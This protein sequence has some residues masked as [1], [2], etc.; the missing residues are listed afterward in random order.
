MKVLVP[1]AYKGSLPKI[2]DAEIVII[3]GSQPVAD[4]HLDAEVLVAWGQP[5]E[6][7]KDSAQRLTRLRLVQAFLAGPDPVVA[8][9][10][11]PEQ[12]AAAANRGNERGRRARRVAQLAARQRR[13]RPRTSNTWF[14]TSNPLLASKEVISR[15]ISRSS[16][17]LGSKSVTIP[18][19]THTR[20]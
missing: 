8:A 12:M 11:D 10:F 7:L 2:D 13:Q 17:G 20:W 18:H 3:D 1:K 19:S 5:N 9:G 15:A 4:E 16:C 6:V 14:V